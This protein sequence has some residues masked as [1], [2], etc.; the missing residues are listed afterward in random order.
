MNRVRAE[1]VVLAVLSL[2]GAYGAGIRPPDKDESRDDLPLALAHASW[3]DL[4]GR[5]LVPVFG[6][7]STH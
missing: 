4:D 7:G 2:T 1:S 6:G 5:S 3:S